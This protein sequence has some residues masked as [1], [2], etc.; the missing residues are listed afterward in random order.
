MM[1]AEAKPWSNSWNE[2]NCETSAH[3]DF[4]YAYPFKGGIKL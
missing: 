3:N 4:N 2:N 1:A